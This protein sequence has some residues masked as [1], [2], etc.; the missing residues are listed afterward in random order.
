[1]HFK[2]MSCMP[3]RCHPHQSNGHGHRRPSR[4]K[5]VKW[6]SSC[7]D[8]NCKLRQSENSNNI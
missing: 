1:M 6:K 5:E 7:L 4:R 3:D 2:C 8:I